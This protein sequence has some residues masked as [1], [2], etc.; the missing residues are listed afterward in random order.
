[1]FK[2]ITDVEEQTLLA[3]AGLLWYRDWD[4]YPAYLRNFSLWI[5]QCKDSS[6]LGKYTQ[7]DNIAY[8]VQVEE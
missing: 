8:Y 3:D 4:L 5:S 2:L 1:M 6:M 7:R